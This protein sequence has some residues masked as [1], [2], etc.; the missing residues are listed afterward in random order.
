[1][2]FVDSPIIKDAI[3]SSEDSMNDTI[4][5]KMQWDVKGFQNDAIGIKGAIGTS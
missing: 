1:M 2:L 3:G 4:V 5:I